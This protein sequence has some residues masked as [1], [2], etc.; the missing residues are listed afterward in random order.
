[1]LGD[2][3]SLAD[4]E[5]THD[6]LPTVSME[7]FL[8]QFSQPGASHPSTCASRLRGMRWG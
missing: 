2:N 4:S 8:N 1:V 5:A 6:T 3:E 7:S